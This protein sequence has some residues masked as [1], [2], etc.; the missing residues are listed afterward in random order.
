MLRGLSEHSLSQAGLQK[1]LGFASAA[2]FEFSQTVVSERCGDIENRDCRTQILVSSTTIEGLDR[3]CWRFAGTADP[4]QCSRC[5]M[6]WHV[7]LPG[8]GLSG[9]PDACR[10]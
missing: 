1:G 3:K 9:L 2:I 10:E 7:R 6:D 5:A 4:R 8:S